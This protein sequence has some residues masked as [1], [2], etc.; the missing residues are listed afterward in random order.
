MNASNEWYVRPT[1]TATRQRITDP[2]TL[3]DLWLDQFLQACGEAESKTSCFDTVALYGRLSRV[4]P[5]LL[6]ATGL[7]EEWAKACQGVA[8]RLLE[9]ADYALSEL[10]PGGWLEE[11][12]ELA[13]ACD[14]GA[15]S[16][17]L[18]EWAESLLTD[19][20]D[21]ELIIWAAE[22]AG[23]AEE[24]CNQVVDELRK[25][26]QWLTDNRDRFFAAG[27]FIQAIA[28]TLRPD[29]EE[30]DPD[31][32]LSTIKYILL[33]DAL[34]EAEQILFVPKAEAVPVQ[35]GYPWTV[36]TPVLEFA[37]AAEAGSEA[38]I[39]HLRWWSPDGLYRAVLAVPARVPSSQFLVVNFFRDEVP[40][41]DLVGEPV[42]LGG[43][44]SA[45]DPSGK[46]EFSWEK[47]ARQRDNYPRCMLV[48]GEPP[49]PW[50]VEEKA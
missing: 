41:T 36:V 48:V 25:C 10:N 29:L 15:D 1:L 9:L 42:W 37:L 40:A 28:Q 7:L 30:S 49:E 26:F 14:D 17:E 32:A 19:L 47:L 18:S 12:Q 11:A 20:D 39:K 23:I 31:L 24:R 2:L 16:S 33:L 22:R 21:A 34:E 50:L 13:D 43:L 5:S 27:V 6:K 4:R 35:P 46:A 38:S 3:V 45:I 8:G 44:L